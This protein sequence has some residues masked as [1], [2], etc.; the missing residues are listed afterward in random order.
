M[1]SVKPVFIFSS[2]L[3][4][5]KIFLEDSVPWK[6]F[7]YSL[8]LSGFLGLPPVAFKEAE[9]F[10]AREVPRV[11]LTAVLTSRGGRRIV[12]S[13]VSIPGSST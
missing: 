3:Q 9:S 13:E 8:P 10:R 5:A 1:N 2:K 12:I 11:S 4:N 7:S 6:F